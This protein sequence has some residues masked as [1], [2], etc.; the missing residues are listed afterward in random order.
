M[1]IICFSLKTLN[2][3]KSFLQIYMFLRTHYLS[4]SPKTFS[5]PSQNIR[6][7]LGTVRTC[8]SFSRNKRILTCID[9]P[10]GWRQLTRSLWL[11]AAVSVTVKWVI[12]YAHTPSSKA[13]QARQLTWLNGLKRIRRVSW[14]MIQLE[15]IISM[16]L[17]LTVHTISDS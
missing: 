3:L 7:R 2:F 11:Q 5:I 6:P 9:F 17:S 16:V 14:F 1:T 13:K 12:H 10:G 4:S 8:P 15:G